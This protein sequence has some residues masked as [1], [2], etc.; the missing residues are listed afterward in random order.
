MKMKDKNRGSSTIFW[1]IIVIIIIF[2]LI[3]SLNSSDEGQ[4]SNT[5]DYSNSY[6][7]YSVQNEDNEYGDNTTIEPEN[8]YND[9]TGHSAG[10]EW[11]QENNVSS[12]GGNSNSFIEGCEE[13]L[14][15]QEEY[16][17]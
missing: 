7:N 4:V 9:G 12:C 6:S 10:Y 14:A 5:V 11:A 17:N 2:I 3:G 15:Q 8:P 13:Y 16:E 1:S